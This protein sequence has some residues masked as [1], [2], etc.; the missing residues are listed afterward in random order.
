MRQETGSNNNQD[1]EL[2]IQLRLDGVS[3]S[4][5]SYK[6]LEPHS[7]IHLL[8]HRSV[9]A[10]KSCVDS[11]GVK[12]VMSSCGV[13]LRPD[14]SVITIV[15]DQNVALI[16]LSNQQRE[17]I[18]ET[19]GEDAPFT[20]PILR[21]PIIERSHVIIYY[22]QG[23]TY[24]NIYNTSSMLFAEVFLT[25]TSS[26]VIYWLSRIGEAV[27]LNDYKIYLSS[28]DKQLHRVVSRYYKDVELC[29]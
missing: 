24:I 8:S 21:T 2:S 7:P 28:D 18:I 17:Q 1:R 16:A 12:A 19:F 4:L 20:S 3:F 26:D 14:E 10:P 11:D 5:D 15:R 23:L 29:E 13:E 25:P 9:L 6:G 27:P 22:A